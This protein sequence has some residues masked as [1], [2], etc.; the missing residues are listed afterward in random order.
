MVKWP[1]ATIHA[2]NYTCAG[3]KAQRW[4]ETGRPMVKKCTGIFRN[5]R[6]MKLRWPGLSIQ[7]IAISWPP[8]DQSGRISRAGAT[9]PHRRFGSEVKE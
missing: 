6:K 9:R 8:A 5:S 1:Q 2:F 3:P 4:T 7:P